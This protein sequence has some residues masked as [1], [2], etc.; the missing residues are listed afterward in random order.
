MI[1]SVVI[2]YFVGSSTEYPREV[3]QSWVWFVWKESGGFVSGMW[4]VG[5]G[6][7]EDFLWWMWFLR[8]FS[9]SYFPLVVFCCWLYYKKAPTRSVFSIPSPLLLYTPQKLPFVSINLLIFFF[10]TSPTLLPTLVSSTL[11]MGSFTMAGSTHPR[12]C[13][14]RGDKLGMDVERGI[15]EYAPKSARV[16]WACFLFSCPFINNA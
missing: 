11:D 6:F 16:S 8:T 10:P 9:C 12:I 4:D 1:T 14:L 7:R 5:C 3:V 2:S 13:P 15:F